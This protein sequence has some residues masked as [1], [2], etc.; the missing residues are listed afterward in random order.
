MARA[1]RTGNN[2]MKRSQRKRITPELGYYLIVTDTEA[3]EHCFFEGLKKTLPEN[4]KG[5]LV[6]K[7]EKTKTENLVDKCCELVAY[8]PQYRIPWIVFDRDQVDNFDDIIN[9][10]MS[11][12]IQVGWSNPCFEIWLYA[13]FGAM[14][15]IEE[16]WKCCS[17]FAKEY[18][19][20][21]GYKYSK[22]DDKLYDKICKVGDE[23][24]DVYLAQQKLEQ[25]KREGKLKPS[26]MC[27]CT[28]VHNLVRQIRESCYRKNS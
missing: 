13:Y 15:K 22:A 12:D 24:K 2:K 25:C 6:I 4:V 20:K 18:E 5:K 1:D 26:E 27:P 19:L 11:K 10:A 9:Y 23:K 14:P 16:S 7:V 8:N 21:T 28:T 3:T 17:K